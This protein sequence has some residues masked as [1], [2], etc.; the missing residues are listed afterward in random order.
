MYVTLDNTTFLALFCHKRYCLRHGT[1]Q[2]S[3]GGGVEAS[4]LDFTKQNIFHKPSILKI[5][6]EKDVMEWVLA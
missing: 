6:Q 4:I 2:K 5:W 3:E 1:S